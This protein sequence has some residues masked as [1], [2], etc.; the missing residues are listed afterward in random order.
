DP[1]FGGFVAAIGAYR[2]EMCELPGTLLHRAALFCDDLDAARSEA[3]DLIR[4][5]IDCA[6]VVPLER[7]I[8][9]EVQRPEHGPVVFKSVGQALWDLAAC[10]LA[11][12]QLQSETAR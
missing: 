3:G 4:A 5:D 1:R 8:A 12:T 9:G 11:W 2:P 10:R 7:V 6:N